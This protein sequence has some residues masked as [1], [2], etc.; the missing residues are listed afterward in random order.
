MDQVPGL[1]FTPLQW[2]SPRHVVILGLVSAFESEVNCGAT[3]RE[4]HKL[5]GG[6]GRK[7]ECAHGGSRPQLGFWSSDFVSGHPGVPRI[8]M[9]LSPGKHGLG[10]TTGA[11]N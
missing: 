8:K 2:C 6:K 10:G 5:H 4:S 3:E 1:D 9:T 7:K 11:N